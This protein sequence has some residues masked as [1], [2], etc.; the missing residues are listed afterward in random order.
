MHTAYKVGVIFVV[1]L[2]GVFSSFWYTYND[3][4]HFR[5]LSVVKTGRSFSRDENKD[6]QMLTLSP[7]SMWHYWYQWNCGIWFSAK[8]CQQVVWLGGNNA[9]FVL[10]YKVYWIYIENLGEYIYNTW[11]TR[12]VLEYFPVMIW[13]CQ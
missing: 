9:V 2:F 6:Y 12:S 13:K 8:H 4:T 1:K 11:N 7:F 3:H 5:A 10:T